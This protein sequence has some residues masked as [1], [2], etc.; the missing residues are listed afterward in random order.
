MTRKILFVSH[1]SELNGAERVLLGLLK[2]LDRAKFRPL[3]VVPRRGPVESEARRAGVAVNVVNM[4]WWLTE[5]SKAWKQLLSWAWNRAA[6][7][8]I[9]RIIRDEGIDLVFTNSAAVCSGALAAGRAGVPH[10]WSI[11]EL[12][13]ETPLLVSLFGRRR[14]VRDILRRSTRVIVNSRATAGVFG[15]DGRV[16]LVYNGVD[17]PSASPDSEAGLK[18]S[19]GLGPEDTVLGVVGKVYRDKGQEDVVRALPA[20]R[21]RYPQ[22]RLLIVGGFRDRSSRSTLDATVS[23]NR[24]ENHVLYLGQR[25]D[26]PGLLRIMDLLVVAS[27]IDSFGLCVLEAMAAGT[28]VL[29]LRAGG[30]PEIISHGK[31]GFL[32]D[33][34]DAAGIRDAVVSALS[35]PS[36]A[37]IRDEAARTAARFSLQRQ[38]RET[39]AVI[40][41]ALKDAD[42][43]C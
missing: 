43:D 32:M 8:R 37:R 11:H 2:R 4:K 28:P 29:A 12:L 38:V 26:V 25:N 33:S 7:R 36:L 5:R 20:L 31:D 1:S 21:E 30:L 13:G 16:R 15:R 10:I 19:L 42:A 39:E 3:L 41:E 34:A 14:L 22:I 9:V 35:S 23:E 24:L 18:K 6:A 40:R 17:A 27:R